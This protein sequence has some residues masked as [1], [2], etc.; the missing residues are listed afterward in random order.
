MPATLI[1]VLGFEAGLLLVAANTGFLG[2]PAVLANM[3]V[4]S[5]MP[6]QFRNLSSRLVTQNGVILMAISAVAVLLITSG[7]VSVL[8][9]LYSINVFLTFSLS[10]AGLIRYWVRHRED[11]RWKMRLALSL[12]GFVV[13]AGI[14][15]VTTIEK[16]TEGGWITLIITSLVIA[17]GLAIRRHYDETAGVSR[18]DQLYVAS[19]RPF[20]VAPAA[21]SETRHG[22]VHHRAQSQWTG[23]CLAHR[24]GNVAG[25]LQEF[26]GGQRA[27]G[28]CAQLRWRSNLRSAARGAAE[29][30]GVLYGARAAAWHGVEVLPRVRRGR[31]G[32]GGEACREARADFPNVVFFASKLVFEN[33]TWLTRL[34]HNQIVYAMQR[35]LQLEGMQMVILPMQAPANKGPTTANASCASD[36]RR[37]GPFPPR[38]GLGGLVEQALGIAFAQPIQGKRL[39]RPRTGCN[40]ARNN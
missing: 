36:V 24:H 37:S 1:A 25:I 14:L 20:R 33:E 31:R 2:G 28:R 39:T 10:L 12:A 4:D 27:A 32:R 13:C 8:V 19:D 17:T 3:A 18:A 38:T 21:R 23:P 16:F 22:S 9:V 15:A 29:G 35:R 7:N 34:L 26:P 11:P 40:M 30:H 5:W 6:H